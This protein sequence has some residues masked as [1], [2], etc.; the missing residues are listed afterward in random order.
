MALF[1]ACT[2]NKV[3]KG[4][5]LLT[6]NNFKF[7]DGSVYS[8]GVSD[9]VSQKPNGKTLFIFPM[10]LWFYNMSNA[11]YVTIFFIYSS[12]RSVVCIC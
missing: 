3:P 11:K 8:S 12:Y 7:T 4:Q 5:Y 9:Y 10:S 6:K 1:Y 2:T